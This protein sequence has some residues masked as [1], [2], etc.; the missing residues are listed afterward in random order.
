M[1]PR[2]LRGRLFLAI[3]GV[4]AVA[5]ALG[6]WLVDRTLRVEVKE[7]VTMTRPAGAPPGAKVDRQVT[8]AAEV[9]PGQTLSQRLWLVLAIVLIGATATTAWLARRIVQPVSDLRAASER[10]ARG[11]LE[12]RVKVKGRDEVADLGRAFNRMADQISVDERQ[13]RDL[14]NDVAHELRTPLT[15][16]R[17]HLEALADGVTPFTTESADTLL[18]DVIHLQHVV[19]D[20]ADL[21]RADAGQWALTMDAVALRPVLD[22]LAREIG[23]R[24]SGANISLVAEVPSS[25]PNLRADVARLTQVL[26]N[27]IDNAIAYTPPGGTIR[28]GAKAGDRVMTIVVSDTGPGIPP[29]QLGRVFE[30]FYRTDPSRARTTGGAGLGLAIVRQIVELHGGDVHAAN[31][32]GAGA[33][34]TIRWPTS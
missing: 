10:M 8:T 19:D 18:A 17:C 29:D 30:R 15:N 2:S 5:L 33:V 11:D 31:V 32:P 12:A 23:S 26:R 9:P 6:A 20:L 3:V 4:S 27:V 34:F 13:R 28:I 14:T 24:L 25:L 7:E 21:A 16:L 22:G 1:R